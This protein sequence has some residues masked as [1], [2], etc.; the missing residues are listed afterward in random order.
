[1]RVD[2]KVVTGRKCCWGLQQGHLRKEVQ[3]FV[4]VEINLAYILLFSLVFFVQP[5]FRPTSG[6]EKCMGRKSVMLLVAVLGTTK[7]HHAM[8]LQDSPYVTPRGEIP[9]SKSII[10]QGLFLGVSK[11]SKSSR[12]KECDRIASPDTLRHCRREGPLKRWFASWIF[13][14]T[15]GRP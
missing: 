6:S 10:R 9:N 3:S 14:I 15:T 8:D 11:S 7:Y 5:H 12:K 4:S 2:F 13:S 1:M